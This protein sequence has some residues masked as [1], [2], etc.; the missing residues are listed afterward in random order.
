MEVKVLPPLWGRAGERVIALLVFAAAFLSGCG[1]P[2]KGW[3]V[4]SLKAWTFEVPWYRT[5]RGLMVRWREKHPGQELNHDT[6]GTLNNLIFKDPG[7][8][9]REGYSQPARGVPGEKDDKP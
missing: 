3:R 2:R 6:G 9:M 7:W 1:A 4:Q 8:R 5:G